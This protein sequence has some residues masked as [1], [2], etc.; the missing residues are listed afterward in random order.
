MSN[1]GP[2][3]GRVLLRLTRIA[4]AL[5]IAIVG[6]RA[7]S[8][9]LANSLVSSSVVQAYA[10]AP[11]SARIQA[12]FSR[13]LLA[14]DPGSEKNRVAS[15]AIARRALLGDPTTVAA[16]ATLGLIEQ[17]RGSAASA[18]RLFDYVERVSRRDL[19][20][21][22][23]LIE[24]AVQKGNVAGALRHY[25]IA[26]RSQ[27]GADEILFPVLVQASTGAVV[28][29]S[30]LATLVKRPAWSNGF[31]TYLGDNTPDPEA[32][33]LL[34]R[35][36]ASHNI[37]PPLGV[38]A[39]ILNKLVEAQRYNAAWNFYVSF[40]KGAV[41]N[42]SR[43]ASFTAS[44][45]RPTVFDWFVSTDPAIS[46]VVQR[47]ARQGSLSFG[48]P[49]SVGGLV[50]KQ[51]QLLPSGR[52]RLEGRSSGIDR[53][54][55]ELPYWSVR[56][57]NDGKELLRLNLP[58]SGEAIGRFAADIEVPVDCSA[59]ELALIARPAYAAAGTSG[60]VHYLSLSPIG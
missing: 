60:E 55:T 26:L 44:L 34:L 39:T 29:D 42:Q 33:A 8:A 45:T 12:E 40:R 4:V 47:G 27:N 59:Q 52:Y 2:Q 28:A 23:W 36:L 13:H 7:V 3:K 25:D 57:L 50:A 21:E 43:D 11:E 49:P 5:A 32:T 54:L 9:S 51:V 24:Q 14:E 15:E 37:Q 31:L 10:L 19:L 30:L 17:L 58:R 22:L 1:A 20:T 35:R 41:R 16:A 38:Q 6:F 48:A 53:S 18:T 56:C 46:A